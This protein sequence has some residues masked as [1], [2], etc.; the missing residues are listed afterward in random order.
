VELSL[1]EAEYMEASTTSCE[2]IWLC[3][4]LVGLFD[5]ELDPTVIYYD[6]QSCIKLF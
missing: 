5:Q 3:K 6:N 2:A 1:A 4:I